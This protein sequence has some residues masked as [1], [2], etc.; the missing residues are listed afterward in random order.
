[1]SPDFCRGA[2]H[3]EPPSISDGGPAF[4]GAPQGMVTV[5]DYFAAKALIGMLAYSHV[6]PTHGNWQENASYSRVAAAAF[7]YADAMMMERDK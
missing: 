3:V 4:S 6:S 2:D 7:E 1:M 5:R